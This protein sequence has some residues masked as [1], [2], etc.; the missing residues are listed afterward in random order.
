VND[1]LK[2]YKA[3]RVLNTLPDGQRPCG[4]WMRYQRR[5]SQDKTLTDADIQRD[6]ARHA[7]TFEELPEEH[8]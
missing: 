1:Q 7:R 3:R 4:W 8:T 2:R 5:I 6:A